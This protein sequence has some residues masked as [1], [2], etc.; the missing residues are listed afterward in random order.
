MAT[1]FTKIIN[2]DIPGRFVWSDD[3]CIGMLD[4]RPLHHGHV[5]VIPR[6]EVD[7]WIDLP[8]ETAVH[9]MEVAHIIGNAQ[10]RVVGSERIGL[11]IAGFE[12]PHTHVHVVPIESMGDLDFRNADTSPQADSLDSVAEELRAALREAGHGEA[13]P[14]S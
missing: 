6:A 7:H 1:I 5:L 10:Q 8:S 9:L 3:V 12:V 13:V 11:M 4:I 14:S 2:G